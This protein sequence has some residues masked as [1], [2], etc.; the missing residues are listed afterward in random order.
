MND[1]A[2]AVLDG[3]TARQLGFKVNVAC[4][5][6]NQGFED[7]DRLNGRASSQVSASFVLTSKFRRGEFV[8]KFL[9]LRIRRVKLQYLVEMA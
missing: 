4:K 5:R 7:A 8:V 6:L 1:S 2:R 3:T 9:C